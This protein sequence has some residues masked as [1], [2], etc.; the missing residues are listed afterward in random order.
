MRNEVSFEE[1]MIPPK[2]PIQ[3]PIIAMIAAKMLSEICNNS[4]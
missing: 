2:E 3:V 4:F 1:V